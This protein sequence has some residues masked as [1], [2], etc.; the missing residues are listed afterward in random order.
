MRRIATTALSR[1]GIGVLAL[2]LW[3]GT[4]G[5]GPSAHEADAKVREDLRHIALGLAQYAADHGGRYPE[6]L[7]DLITAKAAYPRTHAPNPRL[8]RDPWNRDY[9]YLVPTGPGRPDVFCYGADG[10]PG[11]SGVDRDIHLLSRTTP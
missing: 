10:V 11:G 9:G 3:G 6:T 5:C 7:A 2:G 4:H 8:P 1:I